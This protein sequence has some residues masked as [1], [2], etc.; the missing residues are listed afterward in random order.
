[1]AQTSG[2][3][4][5][6]WSSAVVFLVPTAFLS[7]FL[8]FQVQPM[9]GKYILPWF[10]GAPAVWTTCLLFFQT[11]LLAGY[12]YAHLSV[13]RLRA[14]W[15]APIHIAL[16]LLALT[17]S[18]LPESAWKPAGDEYPLIRITLM[19]LASVGLPFL[20]L[21]ASGPLLQAWYTRLQSGRTPYPLYSVSNAGSLLALLSYPFLIEP[22][23][24]VTEQAR[25]WSWMFVAFIALCAIIAWFVWRAP[26]AERARPE[27]GGLSASDAGN[28]GRAVTR[29]SPLNRWLWIGWAA[30]SVTLFMAVTNLLTIDIAAVPFLWIFPLSIYLVS[31]ILTFSGDRWYNRRLFAIL[32]VG[33]LA[34]FIFA[35]PPGLTGHG[36]LLQ[37]GA[38]QMIVFSGIALFICCMV[39]HG[40]L[41]RLRPHPSH[42]TGYYLSISLGGALGGAFVA[43]LAP[44]VF[45]TLQELQLG[46]LL[47]A[48]LYLT[49]VLQ[50][51]AGV[52]RKA[53]YRWAR[54]ITVLG[55]VAI[56]AWP[57]VS[58]AELLRNT[59]Y[60]ERDFFGLL[61]VKEKGRDDPASAHR[62]ELYHGTT[63]HG[64]QV[65]MPEYRR[66][67]TAYFGPITGVGILLST[68]DR[69]EGRHVGIVGMGVGTLS[70]YG[71]PGDRF[72]YYELSPSVVDVARE[73]FS[74]LEDSGAEHEVR[75]GDARLSME[76]EPDREFDILVLDAFNSD[77]IPVHLLTVEAMDVYARHL[78]PDGVIA[79]NAGNNYLNLIPLAF[80][81][82]EARGFRAVGINNDR[83]PGDPS[84]DSIWIVM[85][86]NAEAL[87]EVVAATEQLRSERIVRLVS[88]SPQA[89]ARVSTWTDDSSS[90]FELLP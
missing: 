11:L 42:L 16:L 30:C 32:F 45:L 4:D 81:M 51:P 76:R 23:F 43:V 65:V 84:L 80:N 6:A 8:I 48:A 54:A 55:V 56:A 34:I 2:P 35:L 72:V 60:T 26:S 44:H 52:L 78:R 36:A 17:A 3:R 74:F 9:I 85:S 29:P 25:I 13:S 75:L 22:R 31:F 12:A 46:L 62:F 87:D 27:G 24:S 70:A 90:L 57:W 21:S 37:T 49:T 14:S 86:R 89:R 63:L 33:A 83:R 1:M 15:Q 77:S 20:A 18:V 10:G 19:L 73:Y 69:P 88:P 64:M 58:A 41:H 67:P 7:A 40:E 79:L 68:Y 39:C 38:V 66:T 5:Q 71:R 59:V 47:C 50:D 82:A 53:R 61:R 28:A